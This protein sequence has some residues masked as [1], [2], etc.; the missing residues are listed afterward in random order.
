MHKSKAGF[1]L[2]ATYKVQTGQTNICNNNP[3]SKQNN[4]LGELMRTFLCSLF[5]G[6]SILSQG[7]RKVYGIKLSRVNKIH[8]QFYPASLFFPIQIVIVCEKADTEEQL[9]GFMQV[10]FPSDHFN[11][12][13]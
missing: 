9:P 2:E 7:F 13:W 11:D 3:A 1:G 12:A 6:C 5:K 10:Q 8:Y 4:K